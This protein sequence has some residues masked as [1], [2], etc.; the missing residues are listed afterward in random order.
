MGK[1]KLTAEQRDAFTQYMLSK[2]LAPG[3]VYNY[4]LAVYENK[5]MSEAAEKWYNKFKKWKQNQKRKVQRAEQRA[6]KNAEIKNTSVFDT[7]EIIDVTPSDLYDALE[8]FCP[9][10]EP[11]MVE[12]YCSGIDDS[13]S[14]VNPAPTAPTAKDV[15]NQNNFLLQLMK[16]VIHSGLGDSSKIQMIEMYIAKFDS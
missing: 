5:A 1:K 16:E 6:E 3:T 7:A 9:P 8:D 11:P 10:E 2:E 14:T 15:F 4:A 13:I 12:D